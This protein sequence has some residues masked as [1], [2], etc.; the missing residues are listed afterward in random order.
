MAPI[1]HVWHFKAMDLITDALSVVL[2]PQLL[3][4]GAHAFGGAGRRSQAFDAASMKESEQY[5]PPLSCSSPFVHFVSFPRKERKGGEFK[6]L[7]LCH[8]HVRRRVPPWLWN[9]SSSSSYYISR[10]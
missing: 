3:A 9:S 4:S 8:S 7:P 1:M 6:L 10:N 5:T 2:T